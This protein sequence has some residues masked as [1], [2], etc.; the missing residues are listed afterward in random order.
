MLTPQQRLAGLPPELAAQME[1]IARQLQRGEVDAAERALTAALARTPGHP[2]ILRLLGVSQQHRGRHREALATLLQACAQRADDAAIHNALAG[3]YEAIN[4]AARARAAAGRAC[5]LA[6]DWAPCWFNYGWRL[7]MDGDLDAAVPVLQRAVA[8]APRDAQARALLADVL[9]AEGKPDQAAE[10]YRRIIAEHPH[11][12]GAAW[13]GLATLKPTPLD[14][15]DI[16][17]MRGIL[18]GG[19]VNAV[20]RVTI[21]FALAMALEQHGDFAAAFAAMQA[22]HALARREETYDADAFKQR[23]DAALA[24]FPAPQAA[25]M[26]GAEVIFIVSLPRSGSTLTEQ[27][28]AAHSQ[29]DAGAEL[30]DMQQIIREESE[31]LRLPFP[32]W[33][34]ACT[35]P[36]WQALGRRYLERTARWRE[37]RPRSTDKMPG[38]WMYVGAI[39]AMLPN[40]HVVIVRRDPLETCLGCYRYMFRRHP[41]TH[42]FSDLAARWRD[43]DR[44]ARRW[45]ELYPDRVRVQMYEDLVVDPETRIRELLQFCD[46]PFEENCLDFHA[47]GRRVATPSAAQVRQPIRRDTARANKYGALLDPLRTALGLPL[48]KI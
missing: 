14:V 47:S 25:P 4:D 42:E 48:F 6:P 23:I 19:E 31:R 1:V 37:R 38:N 18:D 30:S 26:Q 39:L 13:W 44:A 41:Y 29:V 27:I 2:E 9:N 46:L 16:A 17:A 45:Q 20:D 3:T 32:Q 21:G 8:L 15:D 43:F 40:A 22:A 35:G 24:A 10:H 12:A 34:R 7:F 11:G 33:V 36:Q 28:L 5:E